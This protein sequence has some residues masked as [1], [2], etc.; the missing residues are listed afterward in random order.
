M[1]SLARKL[2]PRALES[3]DE[4][5]LALWKT[6][7]LRGR[8]PTLQCGVAGLL[9]DSCLSSDMFVRRIVQHFKFYIFDNILYELTRRSD[10]ENYGR[11][12]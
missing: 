8:Q 7:V 3:T 4:S 6:L 1:Q 10:V 5:A 2:H 11:I 9:V 12:C